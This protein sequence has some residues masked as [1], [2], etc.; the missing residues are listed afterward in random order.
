M[1]KRRI[2]LKRIREILRYKYEHKL[3]HNQIGKALGVSKGS[4]HNVLTRFEQSEY[5]WPLPEETSDSSLD[6]ALYGLVETS[7]KREALPSATYLEKELHKKHVTLQMLYEEYR[8]SSPDGLGRTAFYEYFAEHRSRKPDMKVIH[9]GGDKLFVDYSGDGL[10]YIARTTGEVIS[11]EFFVCSWGASSYSYAEASETQ[12]TGDFVSSHVRSFE[13]FKAVPHALVPDNLKSGVKKPCRYDPILNP[14]YLKLAEHYDTVIIPARVA[15]PKDKAVVESNVLHLQRFILGRL[16]NR[17]FFSLYEINDA[18]HELL[19]AYNNRPMK[20]YGNQSR[21]QRFEELD[22]PYAKPLPAERFMINS[23]KPDIRV[24]PNYHIRYD[25]HFY[26]VPWNLARKRVDVY[27]VGGI[28]EIYHDGTHVCRHKVSNRKYGYTTK[29]DHMPP[30]HQ[31]VKG[32]SKSWFIFEAGKIGSHTTEAIEIVMERQKHVQQGFNAALGIL[33]FAKAYS[34][35]R[36]ENACARALYF[37]TASY[38]FIKAILDQN[39]DDKP[40]ESTNEPISPEVSHENIRGAEY[41]Q[42]QRKEHEY[43]R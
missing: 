30:E 16:R 37:K 36:L 24:A 10:T 31:F 29:Q 28:L 34:P 14:L 33:R 11:V 9:K 2:P 19:E 21:K 15:S 23:I 3:S 18:I 32:W 7:D 39:L 25:D 27:R 22:K 5:S 8:S 20:D 17:S 35:E 4:V 26:S 40:F 12:R 6:A 41:Y 13:Y 42:N 43:A 1:S 38:R